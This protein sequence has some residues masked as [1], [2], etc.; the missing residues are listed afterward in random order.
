M[1]WTCLEI[2]WVNRLR[3]ILFCLIILTGSR[4]YAQDSCELHRLPGYLPYSLGD[5]MKTLDCTWTESRK[6]SFRTGSEQQMVNTLFRTESN[7]II[8]NWRLESNVSVLHNW[9]RSQDIQDAK[10][11]LYITLVSYHRRLRGVPADI[12][13]LIENIREQEQ[14]AT[15]QQQEKKLKTRQRYESLKAGDDVYCIFV[16]G[17]ER[18][19]SVWIPPQEIAEIISADN[20]AENR[21]EGKIY[22]KRT[23]QDGD[24]TYYNVSI[25]ITR[26]PGKKRR[27]YKNYK[28]K[29]GELI[30]INLD[31]ENC[32][33][34]EDLHTQ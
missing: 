26:V 34:R 9:F 12:T 32:N 3:Y 19:S 33:K 20:P 2:S 27:Y 25:E 5:A 21:I 23:E 8:N 24:D 15:R 16:P 13:R 11:M 1:K 4:S 17:E 22:S 18:R 28:L 29:R 14:T 6:D 10:S 7:T 31:T 30:Y